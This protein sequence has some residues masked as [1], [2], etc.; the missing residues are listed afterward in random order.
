MSTTQ[1]TTFNPVQVDSMSDNM[2]LRLDPDGSVWGKVSQ[3]QRFKTN[4]ST[5]GSVYINGQ[6]YTTTSVT[7]VKLLPG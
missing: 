1:Q 2:I 6:L 4:Q 5:T 3:P 7:F